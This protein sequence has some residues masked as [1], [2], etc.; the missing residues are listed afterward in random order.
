MLVIESIDTGDRSA[1][2]T[3]SQH[4]ETCRLITLEDAY[5]EHNIILN[6]EELK[7]LKEY[8]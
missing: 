4:N 3:V 2:I 6:E 8:L 7:E 5:G 1:T